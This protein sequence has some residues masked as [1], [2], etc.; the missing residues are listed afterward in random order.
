[1][2]IE[3]MCID[4]IKQKSLNMLETSTSLADTQAKIKQMLSIVQSDMVM[5]NNSQTTLNPSTIGQFPE[6]TLSKLSLVDSSFN[7]CLVSIKQKNIELKKE[8]EKPLSTELKSFREQ[9]SLPEEEKRRLAV[10]SKETAE[11]IATE[12]PQPD[13]S[14]EEYTY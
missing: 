10:Y 9:Y 11:R 8:Q 2:K 5:Q 4:M 3:N 7:E 14:Q 1:M 12:T 13:L 6:S